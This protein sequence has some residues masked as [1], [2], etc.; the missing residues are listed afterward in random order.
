LGWILGFG[1]VG[2]GFDW[3]GWGLE[4]GLMWIGCAVWG[5]GGVWYDI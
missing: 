3:V 2:V 1:C 4:G 5:V